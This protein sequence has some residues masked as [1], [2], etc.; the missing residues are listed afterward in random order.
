MGVDGRVRT[1]HYGFVISTNNGVAFTLFRGEPPTGVG[2]FHIGVSLPDSEAVHHARGRFRSIGLVEHEWSEE[3]GYTSVK[4]V[5]PDGYL[6]EVSWEEAD[7][8]EKRS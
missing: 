1:E 6:V 4:V 3:P 7:D 2:E 5:D 8:A